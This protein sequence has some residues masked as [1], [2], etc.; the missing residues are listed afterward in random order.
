M[1]INERIVIHTSR[2]KKFF[3]ILPYLV[4]FFV[5][6]LSLLIVTPLR[7][8]ALSYFIYRSMGALGLLLILGS[9]PRVWEVLTKPVLVID[10]EGVHL[11]RTSIPWSHIQA[12]RCKDDGYGQWIYVTVY[13]TEPYRRL[14]RVSKRWGFQRE[15]EVFLNLAPAANEDYLATCRII[16]QHLG[17]SS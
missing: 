12:V 15:D 11:T 16:R 4:L 9:L 3:L 5:A 8:N 10:D 2:K 7:P 6:S 13:P 17:E 1:N 14:N